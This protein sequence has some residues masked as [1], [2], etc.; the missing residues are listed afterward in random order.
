M[1]AK[2]LSPMIAWSSHLEQLPALSIRQPWAWLVAAGIKDVENRT[3]QT[4]YRGPLLIH[5]GQNKRGFARDIA[6]VRTRFGIEIPDAAELRFGG[7]VG[8]IDVV[9]CG[10]GSV[11]RW[12]NLVPGNV[13]WA[14]STARRLPFRQCKGRLGLFR[15]S[16]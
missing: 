2:V 12:Y 1:V 5:A 4:S 3:W 10:Q 8:A 14:L 15:P 16:W 6:E 7:V 9:G 11:S 13:G